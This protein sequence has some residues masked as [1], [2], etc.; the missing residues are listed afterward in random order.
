[1]HQSKWR[2]MALY[3]VLALVPVVARGRMFEIPD[4][5]KLFAD[6]SL[7]FVG[8]VK[9]VEPLDIKTTL[10]YVPYD[11]AIFQWQVVEVEVIERF[12][13]VQK[14]DL[15]KTAMLSVDPASPV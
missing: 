8:R 14:G 7:V 6:A 2:R 1:M 10:S 15:V 12:K 11:G 9:S 13:G 3:L 4:P 5:R